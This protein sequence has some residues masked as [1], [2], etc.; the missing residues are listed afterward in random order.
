MIKDLKPSVLILPEC[1]AIPPTGFSNKNE[2]VIDQVW[3]KKYIY[4]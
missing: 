4:I 3:K 2:F 1:Y